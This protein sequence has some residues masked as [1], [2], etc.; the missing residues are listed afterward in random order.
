[1]LER[2]IYQSQSSQDFGTLHLFNLLTEA[3]Q[4]NQRLGITGYLLYLDGQ[5]T[6]C[7]EGSSASIDG[8]WES[9]LRDVRH[10]DI[11]LLS[12][13]SITERRFPDWT[14]AFSSYASFYVHGMTGFFPV[15]AQTESP[16]AALCSGNQAAANSPSEWAD[17]VA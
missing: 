9:L 7:I 4:R 2:L 15:D 11:E 17:L 5:F 12:R 10:Q 14:M 1:M 16:L 8:L 6:Q 13:Y 3:R